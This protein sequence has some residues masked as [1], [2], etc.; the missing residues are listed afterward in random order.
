MET[1]RTSLW[2]NEKDRVRSPSIMRSPVSLRL[3]ILFISLSSVLLA[4]NPP[5]NQA[6]PL[7]PNQFGGW[8]I[9]GAP[10]LSAD[11]SAA[12]STNARILKEY[13]FSDLA[14]ATY[15]REDG[16]TLKIRAARF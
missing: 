5:A 13:R 9:E 2:S 1:F 7:L 6:P 10:R 12:D 14:S 3:C 11:P 8:Q 4:A 15:T 16:R